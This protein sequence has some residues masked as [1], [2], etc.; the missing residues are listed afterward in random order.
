MSHYQRSLFWMRRDLRFYDNAALFHACKKSRFVLA[1][2]VFDTNILNGLKNKKDARVEFIFQSLKKL[3]EKLR[4]QN[5]RLFI[6]YGKPEKTIPEL[7]K[8]LNLSAV[9]TNEDYE[10][11]AKKRD[12]S[13]KKT[14][15]SLSVDFYSFKDH[16]I[17][18]G[19]EVQKKDGMAYLK[20]TPYKKAWLNQ[21]KTLNKT[22]IHFPQ[23]AFN[24]LPKNFKLGRDYPFPIVKHETQKQKIL[25]LFLKARKP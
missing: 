25:K 9:F 18:S 14:L 7:C 6:M 10:T 1:G 21:L 24:S 22:A 17:F 20:F 4:T 16:V 5:S 23:G 15:A 11:Y 19:K 3:D 13:V 8:K 2:F 12:S